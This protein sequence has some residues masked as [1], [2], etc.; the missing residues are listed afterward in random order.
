[1]K[2]KVAKV[3]YI[4]VLSGFEASRYPIKG[5]DPCCPALLN[6]F[7]DTSYGWQ[8]WR[9]EGPVLQLAGQPLRY[10]PWCGSRV[11]FEE[12]LTLEPQEESFPVTRTVTFFIDKRT[13]TRYESDDLTA[14]YR[15]GK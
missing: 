1:M 8:L 11:V 7:K 12:A 6:T 9:Y 3:F 13:G 5:I 4:N 2:E 15:S 14:F 10:C